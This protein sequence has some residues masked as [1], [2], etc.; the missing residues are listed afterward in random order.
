M[1]G[2]LTIILLGTLIAALMLLG[3]WLLVAS[4]GVYLGRWMVIL[5]YDRFA[6][7]YDNVK[8]YHRE[9]EEMYLAKPIMDTIAPQTNH[10]IG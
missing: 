3:W 9:Y 8:H 7:R 10:I 5:L 6:H 4:E 2:I 1:S